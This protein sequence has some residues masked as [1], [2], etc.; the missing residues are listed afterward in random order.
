MKK[1]IFYMLIAAFLLTICTI[2]IAQTFDKII[3]MD[4]NVL[5]VKI[6]NVSGNTISFTY[7]NET[8]TNTIN[9]KSVKEIQY[10]SGRIEEIS[11]LIEINGESDWAKVALTKDPNE[12]IGLV[13]KGEIQAQESIFFGNE[14]KLREKAAES[15]KKEAAKKGAF[16]VL[17]QSDNFSHSPINNVTMTGIAYSYK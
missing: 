2:S 3:K 15:L 11:N 6:T 9:R 12:V 13:R 7:P 8:A 1:E 17:V 4:G 5:V 10:A 14:S 16:I